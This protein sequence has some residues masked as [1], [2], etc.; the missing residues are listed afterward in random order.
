MLP[1]STRE[2]GGIADG[3]AGS[4][5]SLR[6]VPLR[7]NLA[8]FDVVEPPTVSIGGAPPSSAVGACISCSTSW[9][10]GVTITR[11]GCKL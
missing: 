7:R 2:G 11:D 3:V 1:S 8:E 10:S 9:F 6:D 5:V 4:H